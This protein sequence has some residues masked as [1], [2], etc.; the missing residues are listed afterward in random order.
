MPILTITLN[1]TAAQFG[2]PTVAR[3][4][5]ISLD[6]VLT[7]TISLA[8]QPARQKREAKLILEGKSTLSIKPTPKTSSIVEGPI[9]KALPNALSLIAT[10]CGATALEA[11][12]SNVP[13][14]KHLA[15]INRAIALRD[16]SCSFEF[17]KQKFTINNLGLAAHANADEPWAGEV[18]MEPDCWQGGAR[19]V[20]G[21]GPERKNTMLDL[22]HA[23]EIY[24]FL[25]SQQPKAIRFQGRGFRNKKVL[26]VIAETT[27]E[28]VTPSTALGEIDFQTQDASH[29]N[30][31]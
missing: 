1:Q 18:T 6:D 26:R 28:I 20:I 7:A 16:Y 4:A 30:D 3:K 12:A 14:R 15:A 23:P 11:I 24:S 8:A 29:E 13:A 22:A 21:E 19:L 25:A 27:P 17:E 2:N 9:A 5:I 10:S 31:K